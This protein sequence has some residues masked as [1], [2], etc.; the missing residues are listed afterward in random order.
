MLDLSLIDVS[1]LHSKISNL[2][3]MG[4]KL[5]NLYFEELVCNEFIFRIKIGPDKCMPSLYSPAYQYISSK[6]EKCTLRPIAEY[7]DLYVLLYE[8][9]SDFI[10]KRIYIKEDRRFEGFLSEMEYLD[11]MCLDDIVRLVKYCKKINKL[12]NFI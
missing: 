3:P 7:N 8:K 5:K 10:I 4:G 2:S 12:R 11:S 9:K 1:E 6:N